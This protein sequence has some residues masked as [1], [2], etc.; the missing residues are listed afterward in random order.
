MPSLTNLYPEIIKE[1]FRGGNEFSGSTKEVSIRAKENE[2]ERI[3]KGK[4][5]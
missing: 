5:I 2:A 3:R 4:E 1:K